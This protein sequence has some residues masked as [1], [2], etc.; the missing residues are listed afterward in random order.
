MEPQP[1]APPVVAVVVTCDPGPWF[2]EALLSLAAQDYPNLSVLVIDSASLVDPTARIAEVLPSAFVQRLDERVGFG[3]AANAALQ[4]VEGASHF[5]L[6]HD[7][8]AL[9]P[10]A[11]RLLVEEAFRSNAGLMSPKMVE[12]ARPDHL[13]MIGMGSDKLGVVHDLVEPGEMDQEQHDGVRDVFVAPS[14]AMLVRADLFASLGGFDQSVDHL[15]ED[16]DL[17]WRARLAGAR[18]MVSPAAR[19]RHLEAHRRGERGGTSP[20]AARRDATTREAH[21]LRTLLVC[22]GVLHLLWILPLAVM[23]TTGE[24]LWGLLR[25][26]PAEAAGTLGTLRSAVARPGGLLR[27]RRTAQ[28]QRRIRDREVRRLQSRGSARLRAFLRATVQEGPTSGL[29]VAEL[30]EDGSDPD[31]SR[32]RAAI[33]RLR[34]GRVPVSESIVI[35]RGRWQLP[36]GAAVVIVLLLLVGSR[37]L[38]AGAIP[39]VGQVPVTTGGWSSW[40]QGWWSTWQPSGLGQVAPGAPALAILGL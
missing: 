14:G 5:V 3:R 40:W 2:D 37:S 31:A 27:A 19:V 28:K 29:P 21:R 6:C 15:G 18:V 20:A 39:A 34:G 33:R 10:D 22:Y 24:A 35:G 8:V 38:L 17:S 30:G 1:S 9:A 16:L 7:D 11:V 32:S 23:H 25:G 36:L 12:W 4:T 13:L 26:R